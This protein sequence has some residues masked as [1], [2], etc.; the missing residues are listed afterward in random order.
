MYVHP[1]TINRMRSVWCP[2]VVTG[3]RTGGVRGE[4]RSK[5]GLG[6]EVGN[7]GWQVH[8][9]RPVKLGVDASS[10]WFCIYCLDD[11]KG[12][13]FGQTGMPMLLGF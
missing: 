4:S 2:D 8:A 3:S 9:T 1:D 12:I 7:G 10:R 6:E 13:G 5:M 11:I